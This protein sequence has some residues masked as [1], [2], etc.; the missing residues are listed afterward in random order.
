MC[1]GLRALGKS[2]K[3]RDPYRLCPSA[4]CLLCVSPGRAGWASSGSRPRAGCGMGLTRR[5]HPLQAVPLCR[6]CGPPVFVPPGSCSVP[7]PPGPCL[8]G[9]ESGGICLD[10][11]LP[12]FSGGAVQSMP[13]ALGAGPLCAP[14]RVVDV[15]AHE[16]TRVMYVPVCAHVGARVCTRAC[17]GTGCPGERPWGRDSHPWGVRVTGH[18]GCS[19]L[20]ST[21]CRGGSPPCGHVP[22]L[23]A[24][25]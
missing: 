3:G 21:P 2:D 8:L 10:T 15:R 25:F 16:C 17:R 13:A 23:K 6:I 12:A 5:P 9:L 11:E 4:L 22:S 7:F 19:L 20:L 18:A 14:A 24:A 1:V